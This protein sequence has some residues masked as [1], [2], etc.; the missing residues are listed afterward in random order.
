MTTRKMI[1]HWNNF[2]KG[3]I[4]WPTELS[5]AKVVLPSKCKDACL[6]TQTRPITVF[7]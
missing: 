3:K 1:T 5:Y 4:P 6:M 7:S 2:L